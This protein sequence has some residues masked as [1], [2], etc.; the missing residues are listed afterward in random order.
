M[1]K[2]ILQ[3]IVTLTIILV[4][5]FWGGQSS[6]AESSIERVSV[7]SDGAQGNNGPGGSYFPASSADGRYVAFGSYSSNLVSGD[8]NG[9]Y[10]FFV[11]DRQTGET[12][13]VSVAS[14]G[15]QGNGGD[16]E[17]TSSYYRSVAISADGR[18]V[19]FGSYSSNLVSGDTNGQL[20]AFVHDRQTGETTRVSIASDGSQGNGMSGIHSVAISADGRYVTFESWATNLVTGNTNGGIFVH[21]RQTGETTIVS[22]ASDGT[23]GNSGS[24]FPDISADGRYVAFGSY[25]SNLVSGDTNGQPDAFVHDRQTGETT[26]VSVASDGTQ[27]NGSVGYA[28]MSISADGHYIV[29]TSLASNLVPGDTNNRKDA[30][31]HDCQTGETTIVSVASDGTQG[32]GNVGRSEKSSDISINADGRYVTFNSEASNLVSG[33]TNGM[34]DIFIHDCQTR[35]TDRVGVASSGTQGNNFSWSSAIS[36]DGRYIFF[37]STASNLVSGDTNNVYDVFVTENHFFDGAITPPPSGEIHNPDLPSELKQLDFF[38][39]EIA[40]GREVGKNEDQNKITFQARVIDPDNDK[41][42]LQVEITSLDNEQVAPQT[43]TGE[44][45]D[46]GS[47]ASVF[48]S[49]TSGN[50]RWRAR[51]VDDH[52]NYSDWAEF[53]NNDA[54]EA[55]FDFGFEP[56]PFGYKFIN[57]SVA[58]NTLS[59]SI[60][61]GWLDESIIEGDNWNIFRTT[62][63]LSGVDAKT[64]IKYFKALGLSDGSIFS[65]GNCFGMAVSSLMQYAH[66]DFIDQYY[67]DFSNELG[68]K[69]DRIW[70]LDKIE[71]TNIQGKHAEWDGRKI[72]NSPTLAAILSFQLLQS[73]RDYQDLAIKALD[74]PKEILE[75][76]R[77]DLPAIGTPGGEMYSLSI[78]YKGFEF[79]L[80]NYP[81]GFLIS[82]GHT[83]VPYKVEGDRIYVYDNNYP[84][85]NG[86]E[87]SGGENPDQPYG[88]YIEVDTTKDTWKYFMWT[89]SE[90]ND[91]YW[92][93]TLLPKIK[94][95]NASIKLVSIDELYKKEKLFRPAGTTVGTQAVFLDG[96]SELLLTDESG[97]M[98][99]YKDGNYFE[100]IPG[101]EP[102]QISGDLPDYEGYPWRQAYYID[103]DARISASVK[104]TSENPY[105]LTHFGGDYLAELSDVPLTEGAVDSFNFSQNETQLSFAADQESKKYNLTINR[106]NEGESQTLYSENTNAAGGETHEYTVDWSNFSEDETPA[107][108]GIDE[109]SDG[110]FEKEIEIGTEFSDDG[111]PETSILIN[112]QQ[113]QNYPYISDV[114]IKL[115]AH[116]NPDGTGVKKTEYSLDGGATWIEYSDPFTVAGTGEHT[117]KY[118]SAD[119][120]GNVEEIKSETFMIISNTAAVPTASPAGGTYSS[121]QSVTLSTTTS[122][123]TIY[124]TTDGSV[125]NSSSATYSSAIS[126]TGATTLKAIAVKSGMTDSA[127]MSEIYTINIPQQVNGTQVV[128]TDSPDVSQEVS[129]EII[130]TTDTPSLTFSSSKK[131]K[132]RITFTF[133]DLTLTNKKYVKVRLNGR[134]VKVM[135]VRR[136][137]ND[138]LVTV[139]L[140]YGRWPAGNYTLTMSY[141]NQIKVAYLKKG[142]TKYRKGWQ[143]GSVTSENIL[144]II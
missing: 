126:I 86:Q 34:N 104:G 125:P 124:Y 120:F 33:D 88:R 45:A 113:V 28:A 105:T 76:L 106:N 73:S 116:D 26:I 140:K 53:G 118:R 20:D 98:T 18:Y 134:K 51:A 32:N 81:Q 82:H 36:A 48:A 23:Q 127:V 119:W 136:S 75:R 129:G 38:G 13:R 114:E 50:Y 103:S 107:T 135:R 62:F 70:N 54:S 39:N 66:P 122:E 121:D 133:K 130:V 55:D 101:V 37:D 95:F 92:P 84:D 137:G 143:T 139:S 138:S 132:K 8:T 9:M 49:V 63:N 21:D 30:F 4:G 27:G 144:T 67:S 96:D 102:I 14:D 87:E 108:L 47:M 7:A 42:K 115:E 5:V 56:F 57:R 10:D 89:D 43:V 94:N 80:K 11:H 83:I 2:K 117:V 100:N 69:D 25:S 61:S 35:K 72:G 141:K 112:G 24:F 110:S 52:D 40:L 90:G 68:Q 142:K 91:I 60:A 1:K 59:G 31:V 22:V 74:S 29:F 123:A 65:H 93:D 46:N 64:Q 16:T 3:S 128:G 77:K 109:N 6:R 71:E 44:L 41:T 99:G 79:D 15:S 12:S 111:A 78:G 85:E 17:F 131:V 58:E 19:A 97:K